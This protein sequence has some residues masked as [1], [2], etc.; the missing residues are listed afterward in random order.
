M[1]EEADMLKGEKQVVFNSI[2]ETDSMMAAAEV[3][4]R[5]GFG[6]RAPADRFT[7]IGSLKSCT[8][9][10]E[11]TAE[12]KRCRSSRAKLPRVPPQQD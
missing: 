1:R 5:G 3:S 8:V 9:R 12:S 6:N 11:K 7:T 10:A 4:L 2:K